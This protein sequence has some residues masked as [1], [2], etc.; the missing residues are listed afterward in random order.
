MKIFKG[1]FTTTFFLLSTILSVMAMDTDDAVAP[2]A[3]G[4]A[5]APF[6]PH[7]DAELLA[8]WKRRKEAYDAY[9]PLFDAADKFSLTHPRIKSKPSP[10]YDRAPEAYKQAYDDQM[11]S[12][13][14]RMKAEA[15]FKSLVEK[16]KQ[17]DPRRYTFRGSTWLTEEQWREMG[18]QRGL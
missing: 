17:D 11:K 10:E 13:E 12:Q 5:Q 6:D 18:A 15:D 1:L 16:Q 2:P 14:E 3:G 8:A 9:D 7:P 4:A